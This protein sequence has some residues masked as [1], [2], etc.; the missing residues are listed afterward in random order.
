MNVGDGRSLLGCNVS[1][2]ADGVSVSNVAS[3]VVNFVLTGVEV[4]PAGKD[5]NVCANVSAVVIVN[6]IGPCSDDVVDTNSALGVNASVNGVVNVVEEVTID[7]VVFAVGDVS[8]DAVISAAGND[9]SVDAVISAAGNDVSVDDF[10]FTESTSTIVDSEDWA[11]VG[12]MIDASV[13]DGVSFVV[14][15]IDVTTDRGSDGV[16][17]ISIVVWSLVD[18]SIDAVED[19]RG[20][21]VVNVDIIVVFYR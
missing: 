1:K 18:V 20:A 16:D 10:A 13:G 19:R 5:F 8:V 6:A 2:E 11:S 21:D 3:V 17:I 12:V 9:V 14:V 4:S 15:V 7:C